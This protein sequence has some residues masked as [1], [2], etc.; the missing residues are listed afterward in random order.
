MEPDL[1]IRG[2]HITDKELHQVRSVIAEQQAGARP[3]S[4]FQETVSTVWG[5]RQENGH[6][7]EPDRDRCIG[8]QVAAR[9]ANIR[10]VVNNSRFLIFP[11][12]RSKT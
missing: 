8:C 5:W 9:S 6:Y 10:Y 11:W 1:I 4:H 7:K 12:Y 3:C 2:R